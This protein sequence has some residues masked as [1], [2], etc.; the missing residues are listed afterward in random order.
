MRIC[1]LLVLAMGAVSWSMDATAMWRWMRGAAITEFT[2]TD[3]EV[4]KT[5]A[6]RALEEGEDGAV[7]E[8]ENPETGAHGAVRPLETFTQAGLRCRRTAFRNET[9]RGVKGQSIYTMCK[10]EDGSWTMA[11]T[12]A[13]TGQTAETTAESGEAEPRP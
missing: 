1:L 10:Q 6:T 9:G 4:F 7:V 11:P 13:E 2:Q 5:T 8:W 3:W 12:T